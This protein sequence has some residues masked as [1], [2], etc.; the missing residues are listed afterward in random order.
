MTALVAPLRRRLAR[1]LTR[2]A[3]DS[4]PTHRAAWGEAM[5]AEVDSL[6]DGDGLLRWALGCVMA[7]YGQRLGAAV[8]A[9]GAVVVRMALLPLL[10][11]GLDAVFGGRTT[12]I[13]HA[14]PG[15]ALIVLAGAWAVTAI[16][17]RRGDDGVLAALRAA[18]AGSRQARLKPDEME[19]FLAQLTAALCQEG[20]PDLVQHQLSL[21]LGRSM[22]GAYPTLLHDPHVRIVM[23]A[24]L[25]K[26]PLGPVLEGI[27][28]ARSR[29]EAVLRRYGDAL[30]WMGLVATLM[31]VMK[32]LDVLGRPEVFG[33]LVAGALV[34]I[35]FGLVCAKGV[36][37][38]LADRFAHDIEDDM[39]V[40]RRIGAALAAEVR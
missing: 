9:S 39:A 31:G 1:A 35:G 23:V 38:P 28:V 40:Y 7:G 4:L 16:G 26:Q 13:L 25:A 12:V 15:C 33:P 19:D 32:A 14:L 8:S 30:V 11:I 29:P 24:G 36:V 37:R 22:F 17:R 21:P 3:A 20:G 18:L 27:Q 5:R 34:G 2:H 10:L 6:A